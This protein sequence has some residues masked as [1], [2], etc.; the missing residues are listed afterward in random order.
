MLDHDDSS[1]VR[2]DLTP[3]RKPLTLLRPGEKKQ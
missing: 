2:P 1:S 3:K